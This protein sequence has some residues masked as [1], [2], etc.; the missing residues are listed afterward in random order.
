MKKIM[1]IVLM[2]VV[3]ISIS[4]KKLTV[5]EYI[6][7]E[8]VYDSKVTKITELYTK[9]LIS[10]TEYNKRMDTAKKE[11]ESCIEKESNDK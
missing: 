3:S 9:H 6:N 5:E 10:T 1:M 8:D 7:C 11:Y 2:V 4:C